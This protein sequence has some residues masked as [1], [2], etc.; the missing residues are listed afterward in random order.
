MRIDA[1]Y[2]TP[3]QHHNPIELPS[4]TCIWEGDRLTVHE[5]T[6]YIGAAQHGLAAQLGIAP[7]QVRV[8]A[9]FI[10]GHF[11]SKLALS[12]HTAGEAGLDVHEDE[13]HAHLV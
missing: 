1:R 10:G 9:R 2:T 3:I 4:T 11:G 6:R 12:Q 7:D 5:P 13:L 8:V